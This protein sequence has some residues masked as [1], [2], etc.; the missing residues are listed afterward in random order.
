MEKGNIMLSFELGWNVP[1]L[2]RFVGS[3]FLTI[4]SSSPYTTLGNDKI[5]HKDWQAQLIHVR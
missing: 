2:T 1:D 5:L 3:T 4:S